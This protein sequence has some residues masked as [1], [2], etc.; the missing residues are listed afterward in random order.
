[1]AQGGRHAE[2]YAKAEASDPP[3]DKKSQINGTALRQ[4][5]S[6]S[7]SFTGT[8]ATFHVDLR[9]SVEL[10]EMLFSDDFLS[11]V[12]QAVHEAYPDSGN[13]DLQFS[14]GTGWGGAPDELFTD[15]TVGVFVVCKQTR[16]LLGTV[17]KNALRRTA[18][19]VLESPAART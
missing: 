14:L 4:M 15:C 9:A 18:R 6:C 13:L 5:T 8:P 11:A 19:S 12:T 7:G 10:W 17:G 3:A 16:K 1:M 2:A